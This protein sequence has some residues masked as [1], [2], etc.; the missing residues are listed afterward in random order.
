M[1]EIENWAKKFN[2]KRRRREGDTDFISSGSNKN[3][4]Y[5]LAAGLVFLTLTFKIIKRYFD[6]HQD[7]VFNNLKEFVARFIN[8]AINILYFTYVNKRNI[9]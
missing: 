1:P 2:S 3:N 8:N 9:F 7:Y 4:L 5:Y 6:N